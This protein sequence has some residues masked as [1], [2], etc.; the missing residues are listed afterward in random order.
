[1][2]V[3]L[4]ERAIIS[5]RARVGIK[6]DHVVFR[7]TGNLLDSDVFAGELRVDGG[8]ENG[9]VPGVGFGMHAKHAMA[10]LAEGGVDR[11]SDEY[12]AR[13]RGFHGGLI[14]GLTGFATFAV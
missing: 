3:E 7:E 10:R 11:E 5:V 14:K 12:Y 6:R 2:V 8:S 1:M 9:G 13:K 4:E